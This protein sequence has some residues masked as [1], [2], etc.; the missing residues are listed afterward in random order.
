MEENTENWTRDQFV[1]CCVVETKID[2][3]VYLKV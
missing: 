3:S 2:L 1:C